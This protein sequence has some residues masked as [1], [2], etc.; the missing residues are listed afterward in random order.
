MI[1]QD[2]QSR[3]VVGLV[4][5]P[6]RPPAQITGSHAYVGLTLAFQIA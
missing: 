3:T 1:L 6:L 4:R 2:T 5:S